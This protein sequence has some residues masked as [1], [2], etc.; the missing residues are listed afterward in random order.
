MEDSE[1]WIKDCD[2]KEFVDLIQMMTSN[3]YDV[4]EYKRSRSDKV[5]APLVSNIKKAMDFILKKCTEI[6]TENKVMRVRLDDRAEYCE[7]MA[8]LAQKITRT[9]VSSIEETREKPKTVPVRKREDFAVIITPNVDTYDVNELKEKV[10]TICKAREDLP[11]PADV[12]ITKNKQVIMKY[13]NRKEVETV[14]D[15]MVEANEVTAVAKISV[16]VRR[17]ERILLLS[18]DPQIEEEEVKKEVEAQIEDGGVEDTYT[19][20]NDKLETTTLYP[21]TKAIL[22]NLMKKPGREVRIT[23]KIPTRQG[24]V[25]WLIDVDV[26]SKNLLLDKKRICIDFERYRVVEFVSI[27]RCYK[28]QK[29]GHLANKCD[30]ET[31]CSKCAGSHN[32]KDCKSTKESCA[33]CYFEANEDDTEHRADSTACPVFI[34]YRDSLVPRRS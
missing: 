7:M 1:K 17:R 2:G 25:N 4:L 27:T 6:H 20:L 19:G 23:R 24:K 31:H 18:V 13:K 9:S 22:E 14:R 29:F 16:P 30:G 26:D 15:I 32:I 8:D 3:V 10:K 33:N 11:A 21:T 12:M 5:T 34:K 28:C